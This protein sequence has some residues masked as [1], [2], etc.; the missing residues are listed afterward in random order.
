[1]IRNRNFHQTGDGTRKFQRQS[2][3]YV[4]NTQGPQ[5]Y[6]LAKDELRFNPGKCPQLSA[7]VTG[8]AVDKSTIIFKK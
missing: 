5:G 7:Q 8:F 3:G 2:K 1:M 6:T 4:F